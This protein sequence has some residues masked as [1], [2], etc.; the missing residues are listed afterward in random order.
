MGNELIGEQSNYNVP[1]LEQYVQDSLPTLNAEQRVLYNAVLDSVNLDHGGAFFVHSAGGCGKTY[2]CNLIA[3]AVCS[4]RK[5]VL[6]VASSG[7][8]LCE[9]TDLHQGQDTYSE[10]GAHEE[11]QCPQ[12][13]TEVRIRDEG[14]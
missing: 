8:V 2:V 10:G 13:K 6:C 3:A 12:S 14:T 9:S 7:I 5:I 11:M 4:Q 1:T